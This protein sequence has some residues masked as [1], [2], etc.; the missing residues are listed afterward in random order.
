MDQA[1]LTV[2]IFGASGDLTARKLIP[3]LYRLAGKHRLPAEL[4]IVGVSRTPDKIAAL[5][6]ETRAGDF[7]RPETLS[8]A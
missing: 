4:R 2:G 6:V 3:S 1:P 7:D 5:G 8:E